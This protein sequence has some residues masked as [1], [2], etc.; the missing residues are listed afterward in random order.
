[1]D[2]GSLDTHIV[3]ISWGDGYVTDAVVD[4]LTRTFSASHYYDVLPGESEDFHITVLVT[5]DDTGAVSREASV[6]VVRPSEPYDLGPLLPKTTL[7]LPANPALGQIVMASGVPDYRWSTGPVLSGSGIPNSDITGSSGARLSVNEGS[8]L[9]LPQ[10]ITDLIPNNARVTFDWGDGRVETFDNVQDKEQR[11]HVYR[12]D[13]GAGTYRLTITVTEENGSTRN[14]SY[15]VAVQNLAPTID[16]LV[17]KTEKGADGERVIV[18]GMIADAGLDD[19][20]VVLVTWSDGSV[21]QA[22][23]GEGREFAT[24]RIR[25]LNGGLVPK[26]ISVIDTADP[27]SG[28]RLPINGSNAGDPAPQKHGGPPQRDG[29]LPAPAKHAATAID[30]GVSAGGMALAFS[31][32]V[33]GL[34]LRAGGKDRDRKMPAPI[35]ALVMPPVGGGSAN[36][37]WSSMRVDAWLAERFARIAGQHRDAPV[38]SIGVPEDWHVVGQEAETAKPAT[39]IDD[40]WMIL[41]GDTD[42]MKIAAE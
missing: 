30:D 27:S 21:T 34:G 40:D 38:Q 3:Q 39:P 31:A 16:E 41:D 17:W 13:S 23:I 12:N 14:L 25:G 2:T 28:I 1:M 11:S 10:S 9:I 29:A 35:N 36:D 20:H 6:R 7:T 24:W 42:W 18:T 8:A 26:E 37:G 19:R 15:D 32:G 5:D 22:V 33:A 4:P